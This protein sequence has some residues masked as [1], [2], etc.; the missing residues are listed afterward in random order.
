MGQTEIA[1]KASAGFVDGSGN[2]KD[3]CTVKTKLSSGWELSGGHY[4]GGPSTEDYPSVYPP[5]D[6]WYS[7]NRQMVQSQRWDRHLASE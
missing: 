4:R 6:K 3:L 1:S 7:R 5:Y 2:Q